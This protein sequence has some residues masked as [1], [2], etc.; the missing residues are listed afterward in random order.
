MKIAFG[1]CS[2]GLGHATRSAPIIRRLLKEGHEV[3]LISHGR[4]LSLL[5]ME[6]PSIKYYDL[7]DYPIRYTEKAHQFLP[8]FIRDSRRIMKTM[9]ENHRIFLDIDKKENFD[10]IISDS[11]YDVF[12]RFKPSYLLIHQLRI[13]LKSAV[14]RGGTMLYN[15]YMT[16]FY[17]TI[18]VP[19]FEDCRLSG[20]MAKNL[21]FIP[22]DKIEYVGPLSS[23]RN[24]NCERDIDVLISISGPEPQ[25]SMFEKIALKQIDNLN[26]KVVVTLGRPEKGK[27]VESNAEIHYYLSADER[28][29]IMNRS[30]IIISRSGYSTIMD[31]YIIGGKAGF[32]PTPGQPEQRYLA[33]YLNNRGVA[34]W[35]PQESLDIPRLISE[36]AKYRGFKG[37]YDGE[38]SV[39]KVL[40]VIL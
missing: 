28:E 38:S 17:R 14:L 20:E 32:I 27:H 6:F 7:V 33:K 31:M 4:A 39:N 35:M 22:E 9:I 5:T 40:E 12:N 10:V 37:N 18:L 30:K 13:M 11:R 34:A 8:L 2:L 29:R 16:K 26:G 1:V 23:F 15:G 24:L 19:D 3:V 25:R 36:A 21:R